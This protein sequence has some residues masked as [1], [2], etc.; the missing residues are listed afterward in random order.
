[1]NKRIS[2]PHPKIP[3]RMLYEPNTFQ[4]P[5]NLCVPVAFENPHVS[6]VFPKLVWV[7]FMH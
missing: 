1:M 6:P 7:F 2:D 5:T 4:T 3:Q